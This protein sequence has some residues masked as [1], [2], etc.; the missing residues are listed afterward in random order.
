MQVP[1]SRLW[2]QI[3][4]FPLGLVSG[5]SVFSIPVWGMMRVNRDET[6]AELVILSQV[7]DFFLEMVD[8]E[9][10]CVIIKVSCWHSV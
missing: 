4:R 10:H 2:P 7:D 8:R 5:M 9:Q 1:F 6:A 3:A